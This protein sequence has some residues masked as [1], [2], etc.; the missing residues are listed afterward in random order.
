MP[1]WLRSVGPRHRGDVDA[2][3][4]DPAAVDVVEAHHEVDQRR[5]A[6]AGGAD[7]RDRL[8]GLGDEREVLDQ[9]AC[10]GRRRTT[11]ARSAP[12]RAARPRAA[13]APSASASCSG[14]S[15]SSKT[16]SALATP[17][18][19]RFAIEATWVS[20]WVN[21]REY[22]MNAWT[23]PSEIDAA[24]HLEAAED[25]DHDVVEVPDEH[26]RRHD[27]PAHE[28]GAERRLVELLVLLGEGRLDLLLAAEHLDQRVPGEGLLD[29]GVELAGTSPLVDEHALAALHHLRW[30]RPS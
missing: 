18:C 17:D 10:R 3:E 4:G 24:G 19:S 20:G 26:H 14:A 29:V 5:L 8:A 16:R 23:S 27:Q 13:G 6:G 2:V 28:L 7:D 12:R 1:I 30:R 21:W 11:R 22:W 9:R 25:R 15:S